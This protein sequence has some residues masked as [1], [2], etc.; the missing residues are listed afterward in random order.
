VLHFSIT[1]DRNHDQHHLNLPFG[2]GDFIYESLLVLWLHAW[3]TQARQVPQRNQETGNTARHP[4]YS[5]M[6]PA[7]DND[8]R[9]RDS[10]YMFYDNL[11]I[12]IP[13]CLK[14]IVLR[15]SKAIEDPQSRIARVIV[16]QGHMNVLESFVEMLALF[17]MGQAMQGLRSESEKESL[18]AALAS[19]EYVIDFLIGLLAVFHPA[20]ID[21]LIRKYFKV[22]RHCEGEHANTEKG[23]A[24]FSWSEETL[25]RAKCSRQ[26]RLRAVERLSV[27]PNFIA[28]NYP[29]R[30]LSGKTSGRPKKSSWT[31]QYSESRGENSVPPG[32]FLNSRDDLLPKSGWLAELL[33]NEALSICSLSCEAVVAEAMALIESQEASKSGSGND[34]ASRQGPT[35]TL[36]RNDLLMFQSIAIHAITT[37]HE[38]LLRRHAMDRRFQTESSRGRIAALFTKPI[39]EASLS[40][41]RWLARLESTHKVRSL[42]LLCFVYILQEAPE[43]L[44]RQAVRSYS[45]PKV[46]VLSRISSFKTWHA[47]TPFFIVHHRIFEFT[48]SFA[49]F[50]SVAPHSRV[51]LI[52]LVIARSLRKSTVQFLLGCCR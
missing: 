27:L 35:A 20:H 6:V 29:R 12:L 42:W 4:P 10:M 38:L 46:K 31:M 1:P 52:N 8:S 19:S 3:M 18:P 43:N 33:T 11:D 39:F 49:F 15:Y 50:V 16:D 28:L 21:V 32:D 48:D 26:L 34:V 7:F 9:N 30:L 41:V 23:D 36:N 22:L 51:S 5:L 13:L 24:T 44:L 45:N 47:L 14:S 40:S 17:L 2:R 37:V 25:H